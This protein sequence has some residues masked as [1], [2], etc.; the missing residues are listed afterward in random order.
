M[1]RSVPADVH[2]PLQVHFTCDYMWWHTFVSRPVIW[3]PLMEV[4]GHDGLWI[5]Y[6]TNR[7]Q[8]TQLQLLKYTPL[9]CDT[10]RLE[11]TKDTSLQKHYTALCTGQRSQQWLRHVFTTTSHKTTLHTYH[12]PVLR[13]TSCMR[14][15]GCVC[16]CVCCVCQVDFI[17]SMTHEKP[18]TSVIREWRGGDTGEP[19]QG[20]MLTP[21]LTWGQRQHGVDLP[22]TAQTHTWHTWQRRLSQ[23]TDPVGVG[24]LPL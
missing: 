13:E 24:G 23:S 19:V 17:L 3:F 7:Y 12:S 18:L 16:T 5:N 14:M 22:V 9:H 11:W 1:T 10:Q 2:W 4:H 15:C 21:A 20:T 8:D 6:R